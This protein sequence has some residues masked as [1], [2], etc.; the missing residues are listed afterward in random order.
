[1]PQ[2]L[3]HIPAQAER[4]AALEQVQQEVAFDSAKSQLALAKLRAWYSDHVEVDTIQISAFHNGHTV[5]TIRQARV[6]KDTWDEMVLAREEY[7]A[8]M[9][10]KEEELAAKRAKRGLLAG[11]WEQTNPFLGRPGL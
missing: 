8:R 1:M 6:P 10:W 9:K 3:G 5:A 7:E 2:R 4:E 11:A